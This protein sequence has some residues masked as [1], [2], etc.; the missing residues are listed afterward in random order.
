MYY[1]RSRYYNP[2][3][4]RFLNTDAVIEGNLFAYCGNEPVCQKDDDGFGYIDCVEEM[5][6]T[7]L[8]YDDGELY[9]S[10]FIKRAMRKIDVPYEKCKCSTLIDYAAGQRTSSI[11]MSTTMKTNALAY[12]EISEIGYENMFP[13]IVLAKLVNYKGKPYTG[14][15]FDVAEL[16]PGDVEHGGIYIGRSFDVNGSLIVETLQS[17]SSKTN[18]KKNKVRITYFTQDKMEELGWNIWYWDGRVIPLDSE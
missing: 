1:L 4:G 14:G 3:W 6:K 12:G 5:Y 18:P 16:K 13:G 2:I 10:E 11:G 17:T 8:L 15:E 9:L 7:I